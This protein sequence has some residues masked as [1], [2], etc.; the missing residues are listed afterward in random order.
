MAKTKYKK[1]FKSLMG[2]RVIIAPDFV[3]ESK[4]DETKPKIECF[5]CLKV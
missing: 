5:Q 2:N 4:E 1:P 3:E